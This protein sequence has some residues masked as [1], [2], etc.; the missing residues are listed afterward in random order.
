MRQNHHRLIGRG[1]RLLFIACLAVCLGG[2]CAIESAWAAE[3]EVTMKDGRVLHGKLGKVSSLRES[4]AA[5]KSETAIPNIILL[6]DDLRRVFVPEKQLREVRQE[7]DRQVEEIFK[8]RQRVLRTG[9]SIQ[10]V[11]RPLDVE[12]F[13]QFG[14][15]VFRMPT[16]RGDIDVIQGITEITPSWTKVEGIS[17]VWDMRMA[18]SGN[19]R[20]AN[21]FLEGVSASGST[22]PIP[23]LKLAF[24]LKP[25]RPAV[26][27]QFGHDPVR[28]GQREGHLACNLLL[29]LQRVAVGDAGGADV[30]EIER[31]I[32]P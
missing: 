17:H 8:I 15:R 22:D 14:R 31:S 27:H 2:S 26:G 1:Q 20:L 6:D 18:T 12:P 10:S 5:Q 21:S 3:S 30:I 23:A 32:G 16:I 7:E 29:A 28:V 24:G 11:G 4:P 25:P 9:Q 13:D 19:K